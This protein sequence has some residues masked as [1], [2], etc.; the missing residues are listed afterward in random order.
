MISRPLSTETSIISSRTLALKPSRAPALEKLCLLGG[1]V[2]RDHLSDFTTNL[3]KRYLLGY[4]Q[5]FARNY[6]DPS[7]HRIFH[8]D[9]VV[10]DYST[11][12]WMR[13]L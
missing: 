3:I 2:G 10:F 6:I 12:R 8:V 5:T 13:R 4:T 11:Q 7:L 1:G 9:K